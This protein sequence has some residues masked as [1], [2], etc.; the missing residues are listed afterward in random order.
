MVESAS[1]ALAEDMHF[2]GD[3]DGFRIDLDADESVGGRGAGPQP[4][5]LLLLG[6]AG[7]TAMDVLSVLR[8]KRQQVSGLEVEIRGDRV[9]EHPRVYDQVELIY[10][11]RGEGV[12]PKAVERAIE[13]SETRYCPAIAMLEKATEFTN[14]YEIEEDA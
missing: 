3:V 6:V 12:D 13:L 14:R 9:D 5:P 2:V 4:L 10:R 8:K 7:C 1:V 11:I